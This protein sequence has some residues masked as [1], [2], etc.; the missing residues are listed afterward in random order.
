MEG[1]VEGTFARLFA[2]RVHPRD[3]AV[4]LARAL[5]DSAAG[6][7][8]AIHYIVHLNP[9]DTQDLLTAHPDLGETLAQ[10]AQDRPGFFRGSVSLS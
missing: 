3:V 6:G 10:I 9:A 1:L 7:M 5:E 2:G 4:Q 8:P